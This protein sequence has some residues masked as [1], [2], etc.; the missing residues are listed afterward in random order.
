VGFSFLASPRKDAHPMTRLRIGDRLMRLRD[1]GEGQKPPVVLIHGAGSSSVVWMDAVRR[2]APRRRVIAPDLPGHGQ[3]DRWHDPSIQMYQEAVGTMC[4]T[5]K[6]TRVI[7]VGHS[8]G[9]Q[10]AL[11]CA[12]AWPE[13]VAGLVLVAGGAQ[14]EVTP[15]VFERLA[16][17]FAKF[18]EWLARVAWSPSTPPE[19][20]ERWR[21][22]SFTAERDVAE[23]DFRAVQRFD[24]RPLCA[25]VKA[26]TLVVGGAHDLMTPPA[27]SH[28]LGRAIANASLTLVADAGHWLMLEQPDA[29]HAAVDPFLAVL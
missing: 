10:I 27:L 20:V 19:L 16:G 4:A 9:A 8:M 29:F 21:G 15:R 5:L 14:I 25:R 12:A 3:S 26:P 17:D 11:A 22:I 23:A 13:R 2:I 6:L 18:P 28:E 1:E 24:G 7:L